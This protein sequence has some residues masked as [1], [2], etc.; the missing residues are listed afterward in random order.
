M[1]WE[2]RGKCNNYTRSRKVNGKVVREYYGVGLIGELASTLDKLHRAERIE[3]ENKFKEELAQVQQTDEAI[4]AFCFSVKTLFRA[5][6]YANGYHQHDRGQWRR[7]RATQPQQSNSIVPN[8]DLQT[9]LLRAELGD[10]TV[11]ADLRACLKDHREIWNEAN[12]LGLETERELISLVAGKDMVLGELIRSRLAEMRRALASTTGLPVELILRDL[13]V[14]SWLN[15]T[16]A[17]ILIAG[18]QNKPLTSAHR[19]LLE[20]RQRKARRQLKTA[21]KML[22]T[23]RGLLLKRASPEKGVGHTFPRAKKVSV[24]PENRNQTKRKMLSKR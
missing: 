8:S 21:L 9:L 7:R 23:V 10:I 20:L 4:E 17:D 6:L 22:D 18:N 24:P 16:Y 19:N 1:G 15:A 3:R 2:R 12:A 13:I 5:V 14:L 11:L